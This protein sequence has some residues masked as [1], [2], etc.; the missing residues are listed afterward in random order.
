[1]PSLLQYINNHKRHLQSL[2]NGLFAA[3][4]G[5]RIPGSWVSRGP[6]LTSEYFSKPFSTLVI[7]LFNNALTS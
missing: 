3:E 4:L 6:R 2:Q 5:D 7:L 1:M